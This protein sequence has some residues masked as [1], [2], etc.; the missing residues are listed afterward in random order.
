M[1]REMNVERVSELRALNT[2]LACAAR[3]LLWVV[4]AIC[5]SLL[6]LLDDHGCLPGPVLR[7]ADTE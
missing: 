4:S 5:F 2:R 7:P 3:R 6:H 1:C